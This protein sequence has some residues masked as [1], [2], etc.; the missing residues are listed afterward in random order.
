MMS[1]SA[2]K[3]MGG[4]WMITIQIGEYARWYK[5][6]RCLLHE[7]EGEAKGGGGVNDHHTITGEYARWYSKHPL[8]RNCGLGT[9]WQTFG[10]LISKNIRTCLAKQNQAGSYMWVTLLNYD[11]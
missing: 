9:S 11:N 4:V 8:I 10:G 1:C 2:K 5:G 3:V 6:L 7:S